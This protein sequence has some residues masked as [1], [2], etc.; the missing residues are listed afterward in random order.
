MEFIQNPLIKM[1]NVCVSGVTPYVLSISS[2]KFLA[3]LVL[4]LLSKIENKLLNVTTEGD[5]PIDFIV[6]KSFIDSWNN[7]A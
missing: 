6:P 5:I 3:I 1:L 7:P 2:Y 4:P